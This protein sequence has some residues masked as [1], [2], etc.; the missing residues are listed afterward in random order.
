MTEAARHKI[1][2]VEIEVNGSSTRGYRIVDKGEEPIWDLRMGAQEPLFGVML[3][4]QIRPAHPAFDY[5]PPLVLGRASGEAL[6]RQHDTKMGLPRN[7][8]LKIWT[9]DTQKFGPL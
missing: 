6:E 8:N 7:R 3:P 5:V 2:H 4:F 1:E 9:P